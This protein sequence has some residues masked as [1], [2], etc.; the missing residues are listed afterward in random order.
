VCFTPRP[1]LPSL[2]PTFWLSDTDQT[3]KPNEVYCRTISPGYGGVA[4]RLLSL[5][6][7]GI[8]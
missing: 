5:L 4:R 1:S 7:G 6:E 8:P 2:A 3:D